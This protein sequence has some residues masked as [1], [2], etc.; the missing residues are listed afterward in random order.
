VKDVARYLEVQNFLFEE[1]A[2]LD[3]QRFDEWL[4]RLAPEVRYWMPARSDRQRADRERSVGGP[5]DLAYFEET[6]EHLQQR[7]KRLATGQ[8]WAEEPP[9]HTRRL[10]TNVRVEPLDAYCVRAYS[11]LLLYRTRHETDVQLFVGSREDE[12]RP[13]PTYGWQ[14]LS[15]TIVLDATTVPSYSLSVFF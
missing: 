4:A 7:V 13:H 14:I 6:W 11:N 1:A 10:V 3:A 12:L 9:S 5:N 15:R 2:L 8:A